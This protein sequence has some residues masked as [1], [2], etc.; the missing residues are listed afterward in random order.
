MKWVLANDFGSEYL[1]NLTHIF[2]ISLN[3]ACDNKKY[4]RLVDLNEESYQWSFNS[5]E[6]CDKKYNELIKLLCIG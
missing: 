6:E 1:L 5:D 3:T 2:F 4:I